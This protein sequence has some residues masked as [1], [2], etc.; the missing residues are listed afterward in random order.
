MFSN[1]L[2]WVECWQHRDKWDLCLVGIKRS[3]GA[4]Q[5]RVPELASF[6]KLINDLEESGN[7]HR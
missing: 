5:R 4:C 3:T 6:D 1:A 2:P 7:S